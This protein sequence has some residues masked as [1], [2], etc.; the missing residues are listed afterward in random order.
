MSFSLREVLAKI[1]PNLPGA[2]ATDSANNVYVGGTWGAIDGCVKP[3]GTD[4]EDVFV[5][6]YYGADGNRA[7]TR[8]YG[9]QDGE[10]P[11]EMATYE[12]SVYV[13]GTTYGGLDGNVVGGG[14]DAFVMKIGPEAQAPPMSAIAS[15]HRGATNLASFT[16]TG[17][18]ASRPGT[19]VTAVEVSV[20]AD[21][22]VTWSQIQNITHTAEDGSW[23][24]WGGSWTPTSDG[25]YYIKSKAVD[26]SDGEETPGEGITITII[27]TPV[28]SCNPPGG[29]YKA[30]P[31]VMMTTNMP[32]TIYYTTDGSTPTES[33]AVYS[34]KIAV[35]ESMTLKFFGKSPDGHVSDVRS[36]T[37]T[38]KPATLWTIRENT[39][40]E[41]FGWGCST[42]GD[43]AVYIA[44]TTSGSLDGYESYGGSDIFVAKYW[45]DGS[46]AWS[47]QFGSSDTDEIYVHGVSPV[48]DSYFYVVGRT[49]GSFPGYTNQ[50]GY[51]LFVAKYDTA[52]NGIW[53][54]QFGSDMNDAAFSVTQDAGGNCYLAGSTTGSMEAGRSADVSQ[55]DVIVMKLDAS[56]AAQWVKQFGTANED[57]AYDIAY[58]GAL[59]VTGLTWG[60][61]DDG[62]P[63]GDDGDIFLMKLN[64]ADG[65]AQWTRQTDGVRGDGVSADQDGN[66]YV[67]GIRY[68]SLLWDEVLTKFDSNGSKVWS[69]MIATPG[70]DMGNGAATDSSG[71]VYVCGFVSA[72]LDGNAYQGSYDVVLMKYDSD[73][74]RLWSRELG[75]PNVDVGNSVC[76]D[77]SDNV[78]ITGFTDGGLDGNVNSGSSDAFVTKIDGVQ[79]YSAITAP[80]PGEVITGSSYTIT[81]KATPGR[82]STLSTVE[83]STDGGVNWNAAS[84]TSSAHDLSTWSFTWTL[85][86]EGGVYYI[87]CRA[88]DTSGNVEVPKDGIEIT[89]GTP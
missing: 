59:Y 8:M 56:G 70:D 34:T 22:G 68:G 60:A 46:V 38:I 86:T 50:G 58:G 78:F 82:L 35:Y 19:T 66:A 64:P 28:I 27:T 4:E 3:G 18:A 85:P 37:Y 88:T 83:V 73:G 80:V 71:N 44:G 74:H 42:D 12:D 16:I 63:D 5:A 55:G 45:P 81:G 49:T 10:Y 75:T 77:S 20:S 1:P 84:D 89:A 72:S 79:L 14:G 2:M 43:G 76:V 7:W 41:D 53:T 26:S 6:K 33:S 9:S 21:N 69:R 30:R 17:T 23:S 15:P 11:Y 29:E 48:V 40:S 65:V 51:D 13:A 24:T 25:T 36:E 57:D 62:E 31:L 47:R 87:K 54:E 39:S 67:T 52:G 61:I 32:C